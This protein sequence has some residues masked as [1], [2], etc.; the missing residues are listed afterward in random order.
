MCGPRGPAPGVSTRL[1]TF[2]GHLLHGAVLRTHEEQKIDTSLEGQRMTNATEE[3]Q[4]LRISG[5]GKDPEG[6]GLGVWEGCS[7][8]EVCLSLHPSKVAGICQAQGGG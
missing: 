2:P 7:E 3:K 4:G 1:R 6:L 5:R 8:T